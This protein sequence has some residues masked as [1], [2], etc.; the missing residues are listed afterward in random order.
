[1]ISIHSVTKKFKGN[2]IL[3]NINLNLERGIIYGFVGRN[4]SGK[5]VLFKMIAGFLLPN[6]GEIK[7]NEKK[8]GKDIDFPANC[9]I[10]IESPGFINSLSGYKNL[11]LLSDI[12]G[13]ISDNKIR[14]YMEFFN[15][16]PNDKK[17]VKNYSLGMKQ[18]LG[19]IQALMEDPEIL[20]LDE[21]MNA[22]D[23]NT[24]LKVRELLIKIKKEKVI[25]LASHNK[26]DIELLCD[27]IYSVKDRCITKMEI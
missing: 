4:G 24:V 17:S 21:P 10:I 20:I 1:M 7:I 14:E 8:I 26:E 9:G 6:S 22:L 15:L 23:E 16:D 13:I 18:K 12:R 27:E 3:E 19:L 2:V 11:K 5:T 25:L